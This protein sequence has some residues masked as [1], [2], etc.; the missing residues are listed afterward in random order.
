GGIG[1]TSLAGRVAQDVA[2][3]FERVYWR[4]LRDAPPLSEGMVGAIGFLSDHQKVSPAAESERLTTLLQLLR[5]RRCL[6][7]L[8]NSE[9]LFE[10]SQHEGRYRAG[11]V[12]YGRLI[13]TIGE[14]SHDSCLVLTSREAP[15]DLALLGRA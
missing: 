5:E 11:M 9:A 15:A 6:V 2:P 4:S 13:R 8:D 12:G 3:F 7:V 1:K 10:P 14:A